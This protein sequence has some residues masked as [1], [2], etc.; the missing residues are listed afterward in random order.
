[1]AAISSGVALPA[2]SG[3]PQPTRSRVSTRTASALELSSRVSGGSG[4]GEP[5]RRPAQ[6]RANDPVQQACALDDELLV[7]LW[8]GSFKGRSEELLWVPRYP[9]YHGG[10]YTPGHAGP[11]DYLQNVPLVLYGPKRIRASGAPLHRPAGIVDVYP[12][13]G[14]LTRVDLAPRAGDVLRPA[15]K[16]KV[17]GR[18]KLVVVVV[19]DGVG[20]NVLERW[21][22]AWPTLRSLEARGTSFVDAM[23]G[24]SPSNTPPVHANLGTGTYPRVHGVTGIK[25]RVEFGDVVFALDGRETSTLRVSTF[26]DQI[27]QAFG[28]AS[29]V[30]L[31]GYS[32]WQLGML[33]HGAG[34]PGGDEDHLAMLGEP[35]RVMGNGAYYDTPSYL[36]EFPGFEAHADAVDRS[37]GKADG[38]WRGHPVLEDHDNPAWVRYE[39]DVALTL[40]QQEGYGADDVTDILLVNYKM[41]DV[42]GHKYWIDSLEARDVLRAQDNALAQLV[43]Y[44]KRQV[45][46]FVVVVTADHGHTPPRTETGGW[47]V[48]ATDASAYLNRH[49]EV[50]KGRSL[51]EDSSGAGLFL[52]VDVAKRLGITQR[53]MAAALNLYTI[54]QS[55]GKGRLPPMYKGRDRET[56]FAAV[57]PR[58]LLPQVMK[59]AFG[60]RRPP[61][62]FPA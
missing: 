42:I 50:P 8:R 45:R 18:P 2:E 40:V 57:I 7:R 1:M 16:P 15:L 61:A 36:R 5:V 27:D 55:A 43:G 41:L 53:E 35:G 47:P 11:W 59:C 48:L 13:I 44:L 51:V 52:D 14:R 30:G 33:G 6:Q 62:D 23:V 22:N 4:E 37:D 29:E 21:P 31:V 32:S 26:A 20:R 56:V 34:W 19:W 17:P 60:T 3:R 12:T 39:N 10:F 25:Q 54:R 28:G 38:R 24:S 49:F 9:N 46:D 58:R